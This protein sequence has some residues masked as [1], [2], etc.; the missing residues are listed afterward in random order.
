MMGMRSH[1]ILLS[2]SG[3]KRK[4]LKALRQD[5]RKDDD[6][7]DNPSFNITS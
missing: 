1:E 4:I 2:H 7:D 6:E 3:L 5:D